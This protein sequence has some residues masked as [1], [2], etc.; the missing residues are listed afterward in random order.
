VNLTPDSSVIKLAGMNSL[1]K[2][3]RLF[4]GLGIMAYGM[5]QII[6]RDFRPQI[7]PPFPAWAH[8]YIAFAFVTG[9]VMVILGA[10][11]SGLV[12]L[13]DAKTRK[14]SLY[15]GLYFL[16]L[17]IACH[18]PYLLFIFPHKLSHLGVWADLLKELAFSGGAF[19]LAGS[20]LISPSLHHKGILA[21]HFP[22]ILI[23]VGRIFF[24]TTMVLFGCS[25][26]V[27]A[28]F[29]SRMV[30]E[31]IG[32][33]VFWT[34]FGGAALIAAGV[35]IALKIFIKP[36][37]VLLAIML[38]LWFL[39]LHVPGAFANPTAGRGNSIVSAFDAL[40]FCG[41]ALVLARFQGQ[42][43]DKDSKATRKEVP[44]IKGVS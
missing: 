14:I 9:V 7:L 26:F 41:T 22:R 35:A 15:L 25:H 6:I 29:I 2:T 16:F 39:L 4:Y 42:A 38:F 34:Y 17:I 20:F 18:I 11:I 43:S 37:A 28:E 30:P 33:P 32:M 44:S 1:L 31:W 13:D 10:I 36:V 19:V 23:P 8:Q 5:Q 21:G 3:G 12:R 27:Y 24:C 40:L